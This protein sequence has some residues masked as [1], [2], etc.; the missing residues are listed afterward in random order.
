MTYIKIM[1]MLGAVISVVPFLR[2]DRYLEAV[3]RG[4]QDNDVDD[5][6]WELF[7]VAVRACIWPLTL[8][9]FRRRATWRELWRATISPSD[10]ARGSK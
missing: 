3:E 2:I 10:Q 4:S 1:W 9:H 7:L 6:G 5:A 8:G